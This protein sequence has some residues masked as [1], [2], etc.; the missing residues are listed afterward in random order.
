MKQKRILLIVIIFAVLAVMW[1]FILQ[2]FLKIDQTKEQNALVQ[3]GDTFVEKELYV[4]AIDA[5]EAALDINT[6][7]AKQNKIESKLLV[8]YLG[9]GDVNS[10]QRL[11]QSRIKR[12]VATEKD[13]QRLAKTYSNM[14]L[15]EDALEVCE[16]GVEQYP[17]SE[18]ISTMYDSLRFMYKENFLSVEQ[19]KPDD[20][21]GKFA[22]YDGQQWVYIN[23]TGSII[24]NV[25]FQDET[26]FYV[27]ENGDGYAVVKA[28]GQYYVINDDGAMYGRDDTGVEE[29]LGIAAGHVIA[30]KDGK[31]GF[32]NYDFE[33]SSSTHQYDLITMNSNGVVAIQDGGKWGIITD[34]GEEVIPL[35]LD[36]VAI[37]SVGQAFRGGNAMVKRGN[38]WELIDTE[39]N[40]VG[41]DKYSDAKA[42]ESNGLIAV[43][44]E[45]GK[46]GFINHS[47]ELVI[48]YQYSDAY[49]FSD[50]VAPVKTSDGWTYISEKNQEIVENHYEEALPFHNGCAIA[51]FNGTYLTIT[52]DNYDK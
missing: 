51:K 30:K 45:S 40:T 15:Y 5:Y 32:Y 9:Y 34:G 19:I 17:E 27:D 46:W 12:G 2:N 7:E 24:Y 25:T 47:G 6:T 52:F 20:E 4:R 3:Q 1:V 10:F 8:A 50:G 33:S 28:E 35:E 11:A 16:K 26:P 13:Y 31:Y 39:G 36:D 38:S 22:A 44:N 49:S 43:A 18:E 29:V 23:D 21:S 37:N 48:D 14:Y 41:S 42:P